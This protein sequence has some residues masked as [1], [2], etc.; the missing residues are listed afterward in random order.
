MNGVA[1]CRRASAV[2]ALA[3]APPAARRASVRRG[4]SAPPAV[5]G[6]PAAPAP[7]A[8]RRG[9]RATSRAAAPARRPAASPAARRRSRRT[10]S[11]SSGSGTAAGRT[12]VER[13]SS[14]SSTPMDQPSETMWCMRQQQRVLVLAGPHQHGAQQRSARQIEG[15]PRLVAA[16]AGQPPRDACGTPERSTTGKA[17]GHRRT[18]DL[19]HPGLRI[20][21][22]SERGAQR[23]VPADDLA[24]GSR[25]ARRRRAV[26]AGEWPT[27]RL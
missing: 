2:H 19:Q 24:Q 16:R 11:A 20:A 13:G 27:G 1:P 8:R 18:D 23:F 12:P 22:H 25:P 9:A 14:R 26:P 7:R 17:S 4:R 5:A 3:A 10:G 6:R 15:P 21:G